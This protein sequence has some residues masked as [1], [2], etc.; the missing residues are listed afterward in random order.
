MKPPVE[1]LPMITLTGR[2]VQFIFTL[3]VILLP[4]S[5]AALGGLVWWRRRH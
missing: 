4:G 1:V 3:T 5:V 2:D